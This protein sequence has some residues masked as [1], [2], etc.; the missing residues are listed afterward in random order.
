MMW[1]VWLLLIAMTVCS[2]TGCRVFERWNR[3]RDR[4]SANPVSRT[5]ED[6]WL[7]WRERERER[8]RDSDQ[9]PATRN[10]SRPLPYLDPPMGTTSNPRGSRTEPWNTTTSEPRT[11][12]RSNDP[13]S[14]QGV[15]A[16]IVETLDGQLVENVFVRIEPA[17]P[18]RS[19]SGGELGVMTDRQGAFL[20]QRQQPSQ[21]YI[22]TAEA[23]QGTRTFVG[24]QY[25]T[26]PNDRVRLILRDDFAV[27]PNDLPSR[28]VPSVPAPGGEGRQN[29][30]IRPP[31]L[32]SEPSRGDSTLPFPGENRGG[33]P[34]T[35]PP[36][37]DLVAPGPTPLWRNESPPVAIPGPGSAPPL[38]PMGPNPSTSRTIPM[39]AETLL[40]TT[41]G[42]ERTLTTDRDADFV[43]LVYLTTT[44]EPSR[45]ATV[46][47]R[48][49]QERYRDQAL[50]V[51][52]VICDSGT[53]RERRKLAERYK[54]EQELNFDTFVESTPGVVQD[55]YEIAG[56]PTMV[57]LDGRG[58]KLWTGH[59]KRID[60]L[61][62]LIREAITSR[63]K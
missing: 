58:R 25:V 24:R 52:G 1:R 15:I 10:P 38:L 2:Q 53:E 43:L 44:S 37:G 34:A 48:K 28:N 35:S 19:S 42:R 60:E 45:R 30:E 51:L 4:P 39:N 59:P 3:D 50:E 47:I 23:K 8:D 27:S 20:I 55:A 6:D 32:F 12:A 13:R 31:A 61:D 63:S 57:L 26:V 62:S 16:G 49:L 46:K 54:I 14:T 36:R 56:Y 9:R 33:W 11:D 40:I 5:R 29:N 7:R 17:D 22:L 18:T 41:E 21:T